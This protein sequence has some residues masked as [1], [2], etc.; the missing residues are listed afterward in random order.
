MRKEIKH[1][2]HVREGG[3]TKREENASYYLRPNVMFG[4][5]FQELIV[6]KIDSQIIC[7]YL[8]RF[9]DPL[10]QYILYDCIDV[11]M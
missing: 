1:N 10:N 7:H 3:N 11:I 8:C 4:K 5:D 6:N 9:I 2:R